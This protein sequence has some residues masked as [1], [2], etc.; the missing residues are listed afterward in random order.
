MATGSGKTSTAAN[1]S[2][3]LIRHADARRIL[4]LVDRANLGKQ[5]KLE[6]EKFDVPETQR[7]FA[8]EYNVQHLASNILDS[9]ARVCIA[10]VQRIYSILKG[11]TEMDP[12]VDEHS[13]YELPIS[14]PAPVEYN[15]TLPPEAFDVVIIDEC[16]RSIYGL[17]R[18]VVEYFDA[19]LIGLTG[20]PNKQAFGF[21]HR[22]LVMEYS[23]DKAVVDGVNVDYTVYRIRTEIGEKGGTIDAGLVTG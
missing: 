18:Q 20:T 21:F 17:W 15:P 6:F 3:R 7:K 14:E 8:A 5:T 2:Y 16:H 19:H 1:I 11:E 9:T 22:N 23:H 13:I 4:F 10:T 12:E